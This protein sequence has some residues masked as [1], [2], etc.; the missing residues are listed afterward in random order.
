MYADLDASMSMERTC[1]TEIG[2][3]LVLTLL[4]LLLVALVTVIIV[5][6]YWRR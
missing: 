2:V 3:T 5:V 6:V 4:S 1:A